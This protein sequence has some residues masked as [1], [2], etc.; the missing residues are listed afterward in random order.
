MA[1]GQIPILEKFFKGDS[2]KEMT[3][4]YRASSNDYSTEKFWE[5][6]TNIPNTLVVILTEHHK[7]IGGF[8]P[9]PWKT[10][11][12]SHQTLDPSGE[13]FIFSLTE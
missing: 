3:L 7:V 2:F 11:P 10:Y 13:S 9:I 5:L 8:T 1:K 4:L 12:R 6:C